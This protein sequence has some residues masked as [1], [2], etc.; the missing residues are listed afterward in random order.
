MIKTK[1]LATRIRAKR[2]D[3]TLRDIAREVGVSFSTFSRVENDH[4]P[5]LIG[6]IKLCAWLKVSLETF[7][8]RSRPIIPEGWNTC[9]KCSS[10]RLFY[11]EHAWAVCFDCKWSGR[12][13]KLVFVS[14]PRSPH[15]R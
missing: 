6:Y 9:P 4:M 10:A 12:V 13:A 7:I 11:I 5:D 14:A 8:I 2:G 1:E 15:G 3:R